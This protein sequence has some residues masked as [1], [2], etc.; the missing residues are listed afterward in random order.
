MRRT[1]W[2]VEVLGFLLL[3]AIVYG[4]KGE[5]IRV[6]VWE[7]FDVKALPS[8]NIYRNPGEIP[9]NGKDDD[10][11]GYVDN[12][13]GIGFDYL[14]RP[15]QHNFYPERSE[16]VYYFHGTA[17][18][19]VIVRNNPEVEIVG[20]GFMRYIERI[21]DSVHKENLRQR[22][23]GPNEADMRLIC[24]MLT[25]SLRYFRSVGVRVVN[26]SWGASDKV[27][28][29]I[30]PDYGLDDPV[31]YEKM[32][33]WNRLFH[34][35]LYRLFQEYSDIL[36]VIAAGNDTS[37]VTAIY[38]TPSSIDLPN[39]IIVGGLSR[40]GKRRMTASNYGAPVRVY[41][42]AEYDTVIVGRTRK[43]D[44]YYITAPDANGTSLAA[45]VVTAHAAKLLSRGYTISQAKQE[46][47]RKKYFISVQ[48]PVYP[49]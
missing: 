3:E 20:C 4:Q 24:D 8:K 42:T 26:I 15:T 28:A 7:F 47:I 14:E 31:Y 13:H 39:T 40:E 33:Q 10:G 32:K 41:A 29:H 19:E 17:V 11:D 25:T 9:N 30:L 44:Y 6:G 23:L 22:L 5:K 35:C 16:M 34:D 45:P 38:A 2:R 12:I 36:F 27:W 1:S 18:S 21:H 37:D 49:K 43:G 48:R 46:I